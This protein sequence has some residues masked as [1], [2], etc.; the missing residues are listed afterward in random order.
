MNSDGRDRRKLCIVKKNFAAGQA[1]HPDNEHFLY[2]GR[3]V[4][5][6]NPEKT[7][8]GIYSV[9]I[10]SRERELIYHDPNNG[11]SMNLSPDGKHLVLTSGNWRKPQ[12][13]IVDYD[14]KNRR[15][16]VKSDGRIS[17][18][19]FT[20]DGKEII[21]KS[22]VTR[23]GKTSRQSIMAVP[24]E[25]G[26]SREIYATK[27]PEEYIHMSNST[28]LPDGRL[29]FDIIM[30]P[31]AGPGPLFH[32]AISLDGK[33]EFVKLSS[34]IGNG[35]RVSPDGTRAVFHVSSRTFKTWLMSNFLP[36]DELVKN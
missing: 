11:E 15:Q 21:Y 27:N 9:S 20:P 31:E 13:Y 3:A 8:R 23:E 6:E 4:D 1:W 7:L 5:P 34:K 26:D 35:F 10:R 17:E 19:V 18:P 16:L 36:D 28:W 33:S 25:G 24:F 12:L 2:S 30:N 29:V 14:G 22:S 32:C